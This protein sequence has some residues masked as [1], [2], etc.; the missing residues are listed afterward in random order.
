L[1][2]LTFYYLEQNNGP[3]LAGNTF[4]SIEFGYSFQSKHIYSEILI[5][6]FQ[7]D[8]KTKIDLEPNEI[9]MLVGFEYSGESFFFS[10][11]GVGIT[12]RT[13]KTGDQ[14]EWALH[15]NLPLGYEIGSD[16]G[17]I[18][19]LCRVYLDQKWH[20][21]FEG[22]LIH[23]GEGGL[24]VPWDTPWM[25][26]DVTLV[27]GYSESFPTGTVEVK[28]VFS[29][30][31]MRHWTRWNWFEIGLSYENIKNADHFLGD[32]ESTLTLTTS[33]AWALDYYLSFK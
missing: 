22:D 31:A 7:V 26:D 28:S 10:A 20:I 27:T 14:R 1:N 6:D 17:R 33:V 24:D 4:F 19:M 32:D 23:K 16:L 11:E 21:D 25:D 8:N 29:V 13:Y 15:R 5:D 3:G 9:G 2:P 12:N 30:S 18:N